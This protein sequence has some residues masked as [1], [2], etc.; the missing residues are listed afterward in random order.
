M[1]KEEP[2]Y[3]FEKVLPNERAKQQEQDKNGNCNMIA[4]RFF[5]CVIFQAL[6]SFTLTTV[7]GCFQLT[8][9]CASKNCNQHTMRNIILVVLLSFHSGVIPRSVKL[10]CRCSSDNSFNRHCGC[11]RWWFF[12]TPNLIYQNEFRSCVPGSFP[13]RTIVAA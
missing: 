12:T 1:W 6:G 8:A 13:W 7:C 2:W 11:R 5:G 4:T 3:G 10:E 9:G